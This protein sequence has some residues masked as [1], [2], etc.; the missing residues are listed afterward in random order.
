MM[1]VLGLSYMA[2]IMLSTINAVEGVEK[3]EPNS[4]LVGMLIGVTTVENSME[5]PQKTKNRITI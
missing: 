1:L 3:R 5:I 4:L 2:L